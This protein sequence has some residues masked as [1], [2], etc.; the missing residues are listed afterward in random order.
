MVEPALQHHAVDIAGPAG[1]VDPVDPVDPTDPAALV[2]PAAHT[3]PITLLLRGCS[4][5]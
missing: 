1:P 5:K 2:A 4:G 3:S